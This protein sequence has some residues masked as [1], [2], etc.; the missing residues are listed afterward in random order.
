MQVGLTRARDNVMGS[1]LY[2]EQLLFPITLYASA[3]DPTCY[4][5]KAALA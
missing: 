1:F 2:G 5:R 4:E 3:M